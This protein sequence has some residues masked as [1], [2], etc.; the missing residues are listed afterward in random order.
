MRILRLSAPLI[1]A[2]SSLGAQSLP[3]CP[4]EMPAGTRCVHGVDAHGAHFALAM[5]SSWN[6]NLVVFAH[7][8][9][10]LQ[11][12]SFPQHA[13]GYASSAAV[14]LLKLGYAIA[15]SS[16]R[17]GFFN[18]P[19]YTEDLSSARDQFVGE[20]GA[21]A[22]TVVYGV[23]YGGHV[24]VMAGQLHPETWD[25]VVSDDSEDAGILVRMYQLLDLRVLY[26][27]YCRNLPRRGERQ[28]P[29]WHGFDPN[30]FDVTHPGSLDSVVAIVQTRAA[31]CTG[32][33]VPAERRTPE[34]QRALR[35]IL[36]TTHVVESDLLRAVAG[37][38]G[39]L[40]GFSH[41]QANDRNAFENLRAHYA[42]SDDDRALNAGVARYAA[43]PAAL[44]V[45]RRLAVTGRM[46]K[47]LLTLHP[48]NDRVRVE[49]E[50]VVAEAY[51]QAGNSDRLAQF[52]DDGTG[53][54]PG[55][56][57]HVHRMRHSIAA[58][59]SMFDWIESGRRPTLE[60]ITQRC[61]AI[62][63]ASAQDVCDY[64]HDYQVPS[65]WSV[66]PREGRAEPM[67]LSQPEPRRTKP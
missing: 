3:A 22:H 33:N 2:V 20:F 64:L 5:P 32:A 16:Y 6:H 67:G 63:A 61:N 12:G 49:S 50:W 14:G 26:Q 36:G 43:D 18:S 45:A 57:D 15:M 38:A 58:I 52:F 29:L 28:Y 56:K 60:S 23:S 7:G 44:A 31:E 47:P 13:V 9:P 11:P 27:Y 17:D 62:P 66:I 39:S 53:H 46:Q 59:A 25:G 48:I 21:P 1:L 37:A 41:A 10:I 34:Q 55:P 8:G 30:G 51:R 40:Y 35:N 65:I 24:A 19:A 54:L 4:A 42:G